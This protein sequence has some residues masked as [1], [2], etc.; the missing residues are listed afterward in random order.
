VQTAKRAKFY[1]SGSEWYADKI[2]VDS[3]NRLNYVQFLG[4]G[5]TYIHK[6]KNGNTEKRWKLVDSVGP[7]DEVWFIVGIGV[8]D[9]SPM[10]G[11]F[12]V[13]IK[14]NEHTITYEWL[15]LKTLKISESRACLK[16][17]GPLEV[18]FLESEI[19]SALAGGGS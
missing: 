6:Y 2:P 13:A 4:M 9:N 18:A 17:L 14:I 1:R 10:L 19:E 7:K 8:R 3:R 12:N 15:T 5:Q 16:D 11:E